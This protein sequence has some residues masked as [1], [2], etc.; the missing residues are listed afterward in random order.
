MYGAG[1]G[2]SAAGSRAK[3]W[4]PTSGAPDPRTCRTCFACCAPPGRRSRTCTMP[5]W[6][7]A[8]CRLNTCGWRR[9]GG[10]GCSAGNGRFRVPSCPPVWD[11][12]AGG[13]RRLPNGRSAG[14]RR[15]RRAISGSSRRRAS[16]HSPESSRRPTIVRRFGSFG[17]TSRNRWRRHSIARSRRIPVSDIGRSCR[18]CGRST[19]HRHRGA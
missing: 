4:A 17:R 1:R 6:R 10:S 3:P 2:I 15:R 8:R 16:L 19:A 5:E 18:C 13:R 9:R 14:G 11:R 12:I 7:T